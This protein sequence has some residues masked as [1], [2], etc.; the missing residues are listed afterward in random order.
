M[1][2]MYWVLALLVFRTYA[3]VVNN[4][5]RKNRC[6]ILYEAGGSKEVDQRH[7]LNC[8]HTCNGPEG[9]WVIAAH[10]LQY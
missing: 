7:I 10:P 6:H 9:H 4:R 3:Y 2:L 8:V 1:R 5:I